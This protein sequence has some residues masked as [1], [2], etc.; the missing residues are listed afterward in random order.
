MRM[1]SPDNQIRSRLC[2]ARLPVMPHILLQLIEQC[3]SED[4]GIAELA[5]LVSYDPGMAA[6]LLKVASSAAY[7]RNGGHAPNL[8]RALS[9]IGLNM[10]RTLLMTESIYQTFNQLSAESGASLQQ[11]WKH[12]IRTAVAA[13]LLC[14]DLEYPEVEEAYLAGLLHDVGR[15]ALLAAAP[16]DYGVHFFSADDAAL[17]ATEERILDIGH[18]EAGA[19]LIGQWNLD[20]FMSDSALFHHEPINRVRSAHPLVHVIALAD[21]V[22]QLGPQSDLAMVARL[23]GLE[24]DRLRALRDAIAAELKKVADFLQID[25]TLPD[26]PA[27]SMTPAA[28]T[29]GTASA[30]SPERSAAL[31]LQNRVRDMAIASNTSQLL[32]GHTSEEACIAAV[33]QAASGLFDFASAAVFQ[34]DAEGRALSAAR[35]ALGGKRLTGLALPVE[36]GGRI[37]A[38]LAAGDVACLTAA[39]N[40]AI[41]EAQLLRA[42]GETGLVGIPLG[43]RGAAKAMLIGAISAFQ[44][45]VMRERT[46]MLKQFGLQAGSALQEAALAATGG[47]GRSGA[48]ARPATAQEQGSPGAAQEAKVSEPASQA[49]SQAAS[50][51]SS[52]VDVAQATQETHAAPAD[53]S[54]SAATSATDV[55][56]LR[57]AAARRIAHEVNN[58]L[59]IMKNYL[60]VL[61][62]KLGGQTAVDGELTILNEEI[63]RVSR[64]VNVASG[65]A[66]EQITV[67]AELNAAIGRTVKMFQDSGTVPT[68]IQLAFRRSPQAIEVAM[69]PNHLHQVLLNLIKNAIEALQG[70]GR[71]DVTNWGTVMRDGR[72]YAEIMVRDNGPGIPPEVYQRLFSPVHSTKG[73]VHRGLGLSIVHELVTARNGRILCRS[74]DSGTL[75]EVLL[76]LAEPAAAA[77]NDDLATA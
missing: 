75:F 73:S 12:S 61:Q 4:T 34:L 50:Q 2:A 18:P 72:L 3:Q 58:P 6:R 76:P 57:L 24:A 7:S 46:G 68:E 22:A 42:F 16:Q 77:A 53:A 54:P 19:W 28:S 48:E 62:R 47:T 55:E 17:C 30:G 69:D 1:S 13:R 51:A 52:A 65:P 66:V 33:I 36:G 38:S 64:L 39:E 35:P 9:T 44:A 71:I 14:A 45:P 5:Q 21:T 27:P 26:P 25:I 11:F 23:T 63:D 8:E 43:P 59:T 74:D 56:T 49:M 60:A 10:A 40:P 29:S 31:M 32:G 70:P 20:S 37:A 15:L 41:E 67:R